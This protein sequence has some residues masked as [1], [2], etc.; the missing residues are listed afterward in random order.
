MKKKIIAIILSFSLL[1]SLNSF[2]A[3]A[4]SS[5]TSAGSYG[6][7]R[8]VSSGGGQDVL[9]DTYISNPAHLYMHSSIVHNDTGA[10]V[11]TPAYTEEYN[12]T[13]IYDDIDLSHWTSSF[14]S[15]HT[16]AMYTTHELIGSSN[17]VVYTV[18]TGSYTPWL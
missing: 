6:T 4:T 13:H 14:T 9:I 7:L 12:T 11:G 1:I 10:Y 18:A 15:N 16:Y 8:G 3:F 5:S 17:Y 2:T